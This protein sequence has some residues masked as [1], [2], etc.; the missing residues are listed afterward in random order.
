MVCWIGHSLNYLLL[1]SSKTR[2]NSYVVAQLKSACVQYVQAGALFLIRIVYW[3][4][5]IIISELHFTALHWNKC[6]ASGQRKHRTAWGLR[7]SCGRVVRPLEISATV[8]IKE[9][10]R[11]DLTLED[12]PLIESNRIECI[13]SSP[14]VLGSVMPTSQFCIWIWQKARLWAEERGWNT[15]T[16]TVLHNR[17]CATSC[18]AM[19]FRSVSA[20]NGLQRAQSNPLVSIKFMC[21]Q[22][23]KWSQCCAVVGAGPQAHS[24]RV[25]FS[26]DIRTARGQAPRGRDGT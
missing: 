3:N 15:S 25:P 24:R 5:S 8:I 14:P 10:T 2:L 4:I 23:V 26:L 20:R 6:L 17:V 12:S 1:S 11:I 22:A 9:C 19:K 16:R 21:L 13:F 18:S 7:L